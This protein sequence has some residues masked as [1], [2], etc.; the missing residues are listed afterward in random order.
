MTT[1]KI[2]KPK[3]HP[4]EAIIIKLQSSSPYS[5]GCKL[6]VCPN[7][8]DIGNIRNSPRRPIII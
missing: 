7:L 4:K 3:G 6:I 8:L 5:S 2:A 1:N